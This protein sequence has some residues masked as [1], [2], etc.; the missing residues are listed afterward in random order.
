MGDIAV[1]LYDVSEIYLAARVGA[2]SGGFSDEESGLVDAL[3]G[4]CT[5]IALEPFYFARHD[6]SSLFLENRI[7]SCL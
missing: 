5:V 7:Q 6:D 4:A 2:V 3:V 1:E